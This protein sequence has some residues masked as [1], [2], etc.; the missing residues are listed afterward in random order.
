MPSFDAKTQALIQDL[1]DV[2]SAQHFLERFSEEHSRIARSLFNDAGL[3]SDVLA[4]AAWSPL[5]ATTLEQSPGYIS[6]LN[7]ERSDPRVR[8]PDELKESLGRFALTNSTL[9]TQVQLARFRR[10]EL[11]RIYLHDIR[12]TQTIVETTEELSNLADAVLEYALTLARQELDNKYGSPQFRD[13]RARL[14]TAEF[15]VVALGKLG[16]HELNYASDIDLLFLYSD[17]G[18]T[19]GHGT[20]GEVGNREYFVKLAERVTLLVGQPTGEGAAYRVDLRLRPFGRDGL[21]A[22]SVDEAVRYYREKAQRWELQA[23]IRARA[24]AGS[25]ALYSRFADAVRSHVFRAEVSVP[26]ALASVRTAKQKIDHEER[27]R[28]RGFNVKLGRGGIREIEFIAQALQL[29]HAGRD[30]WLRAPHTLITLGRL[31][32]R[33]LISELERT[34]LSEAYEF[35]RRV[36]HRLQ[37]EHGLQTH[38]VPVESQARGLVARRMN[39]K[40]VQALADFDSALESHASNVQRAYQ[41]VFSNVVGSDQAPERPEADRESPRAGLNIDA[42]R[43]AA[44]AA[45]SVFATRLTGLSG[46]QEEDIE[47]VL[48]LLERAAAT[49]LNRSRALMMA[50]R[51]AAS[52]EKSS[53]PLTF[54]ATSLTELIKLCGASEFFAEMLA[55]NP[56]LISSLGGG[57]FVKPDY[58]AV[59]R[60]RIDKEKTLAG[61]LSCLRQEWARLLLE[62]GR[63]D[64]GGTLSLLE[65]NASQT[66]LA[67][68]SI[69]I[70]YLIAR[71]ELARRFGSFAAGPR[72][73]VLGLGRLASSGVDYGSDLDLVFVYDAK[74]PTPIAGLTKD[75]AYARLA[76]LMVVALSSITRAGHLY[77]VDLR[78]RPNGNDGPLVSSSDA[79]LEYMNERAA[80]WEWLAYV[81]LRAIAGDLEFGRTVEERARTI[82]HRAANKAAH[83]EL[84][85]ETRRVRERLEQEHTKPGRQDRIDIKYGPGGML[86][87]YFATRYLQL[88]Y[89]QP[90]QGAERTTFSTLALLKMAGALPE[91]R[92][93]V[94]NDGYGFL[95]RV[96]HEQ[97]LLLGRSI[98]VPPA[99]HTIAIDIAR[100]LQYES[101]ASLIADLRE[102]MAAIHKT[103]DEI[104]QP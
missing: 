38:T 91:Q 2:T 64:A 26:E 94:L 95:R 59:L 96:D 13:H 25:S 65:S 48:G 68:A 88:R 1:P 58:R 77:H 89:N 49:S 103:Y 47:L 37:M 31:A 32:D 20:R 21:L 70:A 99:A 76:E 41:R 4:V 55:A 17:D 75:E 100:K 19:S 56:E 79:L 14:A 51:V 71:R 82:V 85:R 61:E 90:D 40:G 28:G 33:K 46:A 43:S 29:A 81:K 72:L 11:L 16:S 27:R 6:W 45:A 36:E 54:N 22:A 10:R 69:N 98:R 8:T 44:Y 39:F 9:N 87:V 86:D 24:A 3:L 63:N 7:R 80:I 53:K 92:F 78:L 57:P 101:S 97:R 35:L 5:L 102:T 34:E 52:V 67:V 18:E 104:L 83:D 12:R 23:L 62:I 74:V 84:Q 42:T 93:E 15:C 60:S 50:A 73:S 30:P 66:E